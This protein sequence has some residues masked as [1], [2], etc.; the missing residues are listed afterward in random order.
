MGNDSPKSQVRREIPENHGILQIGSSGSGEKVVE[1][2][3]RFQDGTYVITKS[4]RLNT[5]YA[6]WGDEF[7]ITV[8]GKQV[9]CQRTDEPNHHWSMNL[10]VSLPRVERKPAKAPERKP[11]KCSE[12]LPTQHP[13]CMQKGHDVEYKSMG[14]ARVEHDTA[15][16]S[17][18]SRVDN[19]EMTDQDEMKI[20]AHVKAKYGLA[21]GDV[22]AKVESLRMHDKLSNIAEEIVNE[23]TSHIKQSG[24]WGVIFCRRCLE[25]RHI[26]G[27][28]IRRCKPQTS[29]I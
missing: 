28:G 20:E 1:T 6:D 5:D 24:E 4:D 29:D 7:K 21:S 16:K 9:I 19:N 3:G 12:Q 13:V 8:R 22:K 10:T 25:M 2:D 18:Q 23:M 27:A 11:A 15:M 26:S 14:N 17:F